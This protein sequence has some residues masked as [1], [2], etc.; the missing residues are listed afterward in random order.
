MNAKVQIHLSIPKTMYIKM[1]LFFAGSV[2]AMYVYN[3]SQ[4][5]CYLIYSLV[6]YFSNK[7]LNMEKVFVL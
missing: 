1:Y 6:I 3:L 2:F 4:T 7:F 5:S